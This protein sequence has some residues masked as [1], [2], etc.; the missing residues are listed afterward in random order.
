MTLLVGNGIA[1]IDS[2]NTF[3]TFSLLLIINSI[4]LIGLIVTQ[5]ENTKDITGNQPSST[6][7]FE[8]ITWISF[9]LQLSLLL[10][11]IKT[12]DF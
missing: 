3:S 10:I 7:P 12:T 11:K 5:N 9:V 8:K 1:E 4:V 2:I 6:N